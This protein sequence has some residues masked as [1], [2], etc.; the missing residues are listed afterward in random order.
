[1]L[2]VAFGSHALGLYNL[3][4]IIAI[5]GPLMST[6]VMFALVVTIVQYVIS[7]SSGTAH[8]MSGNAIYDIFMGAPL[9]PRIGPLDLKMF[10]EIRVPWIMLFFL[11][12]SAAISQYETYGS[13]SAPMVKSSSY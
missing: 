12:V 10:S 8:R 13:V 2:V 1:M 11:S 5:V 4:R 6:A 7:T 3:A 9:N